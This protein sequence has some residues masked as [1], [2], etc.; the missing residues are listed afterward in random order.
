AA[1]ATD[2]ARF[3][4]GKTFYA[5]L[6]AIIEGIATEIVSTLYSAELISS[7]LDGTVKESVI[8]HPA[9]STGFDHGGQ[10]LDIRVQISVS[11]HGLRG[12]AVQQLLPGDAGPP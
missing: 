4:D 11:G 2:P 3:Q 1:R 12:H 5:G 7:S 10:K 9:W 6:E 8:Q